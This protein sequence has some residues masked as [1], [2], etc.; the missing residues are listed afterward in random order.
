MLEAPAPK[1]VGVWLLSL[2]E[3]GLTPSQELAVTVGH[4]LPLCPCYLLTYAA[5]GRCKIRQV[6]G[7]IK[8]AGD[9]TTQEVSIATI[10]RFSFPPECYIIIMARTELKCPSVCTYTHST[11]HRPLAFQFLYSMKQ[12]A[13]DC[14]S[15]SHAGSRPARTAC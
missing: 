1:P 13:P 7:K 10:K 2:L 3:A 11:A 14:R 12:T 15:R 8:N 9:I 6:T 5:P 4:L